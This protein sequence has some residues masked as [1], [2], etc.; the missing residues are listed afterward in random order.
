MDAPDLDVLVTGTGRCGS[1][2]VSMVLHQ[3]FGICMGHGINMVASS[4]ATR[5]A[6]HR[7]GTWEYK[8]NASHFFKID[9]TWKTPVESVLNYLATSHTICDSE[10]KGI[11]APFLSQLDR[12]KWLKLHEAFNTRLVIWAWR[13]AEDVIHSMTKKHRAQVGKARIRKVSWVHRGLW[14]MEEAFHKAPFEVLKVD[15]TNEV[16]REELIE[17]LTPAIE[18]LK[19]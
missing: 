8:T 19:G 10:L 13:P 5:K 1:S 14:Y 6:F 15:F 7:W 2:F 17:I 4:D 3:D 12:E 18:K 11:K 9:D 16:S